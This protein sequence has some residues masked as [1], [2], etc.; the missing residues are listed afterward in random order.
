MFLNKFARTVQSAKLIRFTQW[1]FT[2]LESEEPWPRVN[3]ITR[4]RRRVM[5]DRSIRFNTNSPKPPRSKPW[6]LNAKNAVTCI[7][8]TAYAY[9]N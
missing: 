8:K 7:T 9:E 2:R 5:V 4:E 6:G 3:A 1:A